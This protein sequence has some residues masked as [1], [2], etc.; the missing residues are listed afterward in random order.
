MHG[1]PLSWPSLQQEGTQLEVVP[2]RLDQAK[3]VGRSSN[4][5][6]FCRPGSDFVCAESP[7]LLRSF[8]RRTPLPPALAVG[9]P[10]RPVRHA[11]FTTRASYDAVLERI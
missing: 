11:S 1:V 7:R 9:M 8:A 3:V 10:R 2:Q 4:T 5:R 6:N